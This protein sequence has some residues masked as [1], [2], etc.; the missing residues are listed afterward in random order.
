MDKH[1]HIV[2]FDVP[3]PADYGGVIDVFYKLMWLHKSGIKI[4]L[5][6]FTKGR[7]APPQLSKYCHSITYYQRKT[8][9]QGLFLN[10][11]Y[12]VQSRSDAML[13][14]NLQR[15]NYPIFF[16]GIHSTY[17]LQ[18]NMLPDRKVFVRLHNVEHKYYHQLAKH[19][20]NILKK[21]YFSWESRLLKTYEKKIANKAML[22]SL[23]MD[24]MLFF[25]SEYQV[26]NIQFLPAFLPWNNLAAQPGNGCFCLY[27]GNLAV[28]EN[29][30]AADWLINEV[31]NSLEIPLVIAGK[32]PS[33]PLQ[34]LAQSH[35]HTCMV[36]NPGENEMQDLIKK[37]QVNILPSFNNTGVKLKLLNAL[38]NGRHCLVN[39]A[40]VNGAE[41][42][43]LCTISNSPAEFK[44]Q[45][46]KLFHQQFTQ[47]ELQKRE[48]VLLQIY[49]NEKNARQL[50]EWIY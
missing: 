6:C 42:N 22:F 33:L 16:E 12:I 26:K 19:E 38:Y 32:N 7:T 34:T 1:L 20:N 41:I 35:A 8:K 17:F 36:I 40:A 30:I 29:E 18:K 46:Q 2:S 21:I 3:W 48:Q 13:L 45:V 4:H 31:F 5:H 15:D 50:I 47:E 43:R 49:N 23:S 27:H 25:K 14:K 28:N 44:V 9:L 37:A 39:D 10:I 11:P 24:D